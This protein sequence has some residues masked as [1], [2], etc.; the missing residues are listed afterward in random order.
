MFTN[1]KKKEEEIPLVDLTLFRTCCMRCTRLH[2]HSSNLLIL[3]GIYPLLMAWAYT[4]FFL[5]QRDGR[6]S[7]AQAPPAFRCNLTS[8]HQLLCVSLL[9]LPPPTPLLQ[10]HSKL[11]PLASQGLPTAE[12]AALYER[13]AAASPP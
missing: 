7:A 11:L 2:L 1:E 13:V 5:F 12:A 9:G 4:P 6:M 8:F 10:P 3:A